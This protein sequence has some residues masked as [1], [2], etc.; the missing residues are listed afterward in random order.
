MRW[1]SRGSQPLSRDPACAGD[2]GPSPAPT[3]ST[4]VGGGNLRLT[5]EEIQRHNEDMKVD[6]EINLRRMG[7]HFESQHWGT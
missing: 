5:R 1:W 2:R 6:D 7:W 3:V 4:G